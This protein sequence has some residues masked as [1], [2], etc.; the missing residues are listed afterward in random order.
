MTFF[1]FGEVIKK[2]TEYVLFGI[3]WDY[4][5]SIELPN[6]AIAPEKIREVTHNLALTTELGFRIPEF[7]V[8]DLGDVKI[9]AQGQYVKQIIKNIEDFIH[10]IYKE[11]QDTIPIM[12]GG[13]HFCSYPVIKTVG[14]NLTK[15]EDFGV[16]IFDAH[17]DFY[18]HWDKGVFSHA[19][20]THRVFDLDFINKSNL[21]IAGVRD[22]DIP[23]LK[24][25]E[26]EGITHLD[27]HLLSELSLSEYIEKI[28]EFF[29][30]SNITNL[31][32]SIDVDALDPSIAPAT[33]FAIPGGFSYRKMWK[34]LQEI[35]KN[36]NVIGFDVVEVAPNLDNQ[37]SVTSILAAKLI[38]EMISFIEKTKMI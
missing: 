5:T 7:K 33:G 1:D 12:I 3:P 23:E 13:D 8:V 36:F 26:E 38:T 19:T 18:Q 31:Y 11:K 16:L 17:L 30:T 28:I 10:K 14:E 37:N 4:L 15:K 9:E 27:A 21:L 34:I 6:S 22:V 2:D 20:I 25:A 29:K 32:I 35:A 24:I